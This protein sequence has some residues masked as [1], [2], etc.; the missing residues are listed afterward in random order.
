MRRFFLTGLAVSAWILASSAARANLLVNGDFETP[1]VPD[2]SF[3]NFTTAMNM[4][5][6]TVD[7]PEV[8]I[9]KGDFVQNGFHFLA[10]S[11]NQWLDLTGDGS[12]STTDGIQQSVATTAGAHYSLTFWV[13]NVVDP[14]GIF[15]TTSDVDVLINGVAIITAQNPLGAGSP[16][17]TWAQFNLPFT[18]TGATTLIEF[19]NADGP[20]DNSNGL[21]NVSL[22]QTGGPSGVPLPAA[23]WQGLALMAFLLG[24]KF[25]FRS[26]CCQ[27]A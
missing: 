11:G 3:T 22:V 2:A 8:S 16:D 18:A 1:V 23:A 21:D 15:G 20:S 9:V 19:R 25:I 6:W 24:A 13:G 17:L 14:N 10:E 7:G 4:G 26:R 12:N 27:I 5:G